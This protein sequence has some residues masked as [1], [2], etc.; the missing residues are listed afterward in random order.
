MAEDSLNLTHLSEPTDIVQA[1]QDVVLYTDASGIIK[2]NNNTG[3]DYLPEAMTVEIPFWQALQLGSQS[4]KATLKK[5]PEHTINEVSGPE[6]RSFLVRIIPL[7]AEISSE[8]GYIVIATDNRSMEELFEY[9]KERLYDNITAWSDSLTLFNS[10]FDTVKDAT[11]LV[12]ESGTVVA[13]N[14][15]AVKQH[16]KDS[17][18]GTDFEELFNR[19][20]RKDLRQAVKQLSPGKIWTK[21]IVAYDSEGETFPCEATLRKIKFTGYTL[22][23]LILHDLSDHIELKE[24]LKDKKEE[25]ERMNIALRQVI[26][27][28]E[29]DRQ[30]FRENLTNQVKKQMLPAINNIAKADEAEVREGYKSVIEE[31]LAELAG[32]NSFESDAGLLRLSAREIEVCRLIQLGKGGKEVAASLNL[33]FETVQTHRKNIRKKLGLRGKKMS[34]YSYLR[35]KPLL[36]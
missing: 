28:V 8:H 36:S 26:K 7:V 34:L 35:R 30:E 19:R 13:A 14:P 23:Q 15:A 12:D 6:G 1:W 17:L 32:E 3:I 25:V 9:Y 10:V 20:F 16:S 29:E 24:N 4:L 11:L 22:F 21:N 2:K 31:H 18:I 27:T 5:Y 33:S